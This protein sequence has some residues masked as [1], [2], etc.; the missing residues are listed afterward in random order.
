MGVGPTCLAMWCP[1][2]ASSTSSISPWISAVIS[3]CPVS[4]VEWGVHLSRP[5]RAG[6]REQILRG[7]GIN[8]PFLAAHPGSCLDLKRWLND[9]YA[10]LYD[11]ISLAT[12]LPLVLLGSLTEIPLVNGIIAHME[13]APVNFS[14]KLNLRQMAGVLARAQ[15][16][17]CNDSA[18]MH[19]AAAV[20]TP[21]MALFGP[22]DS[23]ETSP[24]GTIHRVVERE[25]PC[26]YGC[27]ENTCRY[28][29][30][31]A[32][33]RGISVEMALSIFNQMFQK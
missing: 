24:Y 7:S 1:T 27:D 10:E 23:N 16:F 29:E 30:R 9:R 18:P 13:Q 14:G 21:V 25:M 8:G 22:S 20:D 31:H 17:V 11:R 5:K 12:G 15:A 3:G 6:K 26:R 33:M 4:E 19:V 32:C 28:S 2:P